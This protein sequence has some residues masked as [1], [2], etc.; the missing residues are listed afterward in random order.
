MNS[1][2]GGPDLTHLSSTR[3][4]TLAGSLAS[5]PPR[6]DAEQPMTFAAR[7]A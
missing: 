5:S 4:G 3:L 1:T 7:L 6:I 2:I